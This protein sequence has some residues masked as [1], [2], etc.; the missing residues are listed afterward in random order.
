[1]SATRE[2]AVLKHVVLGTTARTVG[3]KGVQ[4]EPPASQLHTVGGQDQRGSPAGQVL[5]EA[6]EQGRARGF[7]QGLHEGME[8]G[9]G[10]GFQEG[11]KDGR[12][13]AESRV[14]ARMDAEIEAARAQLGREA[15][16]NEQSRRQAHAASVALLDDLLGELERTRAQRMQALE[17]EAAR[18]A[19]S[20][21]CTVLGDKSGRA[22]IVADLVHHAFEKLR[23]QA[24]LQVR[25][26]PDDLNALNADDAARAVLDLHHKV[27][28]T[29]DA[30]LAPG[31][32]M[33]STDHGTLDAGLFTQL[34]RLR[35]A[36]TQHGAA[37]P[38][39]E[40]GA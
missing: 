29:G 38:E 5:A 23:Q 8:E 2:A 35:A 1:M 28:R 30:R 10:R 22:G 39:S 14:H 3:R 25:L 18:L 6:L 7:A 16:D 20:V 26:H 32:C 4:P 19:F 21:V 15:A 13:E 36:W 31:G 34:E 12:A 24:L 37:R 27:E 33:I 40:A 9:R 11:L 17:I